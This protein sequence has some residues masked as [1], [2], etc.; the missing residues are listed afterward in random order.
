M[1]RMD[2]TKAKQKIKEPEKRFQGTHWPL[3]NRIDRLEVGAVIK[4]SQLNLRVLSFH[5]VI[6]VGQSY[7]SCV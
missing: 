5:A 2:R 3:S 6:D 1:S 4:Q 7:R